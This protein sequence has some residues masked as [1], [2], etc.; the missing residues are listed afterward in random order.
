MGCLG[1]RLKRR[2][3]GGL[4]GNKFRLLKR[5]YRELRRNVH[6]R[7]LS[8][9]D[10]AYHVLAR[11]H[12]HR[13][14]PQLVDICT[15]GESG[16]QVSIWPRVGQP[17]LLFVEVLKEQVDHL[18]LEDVLRVILDV[19]ARRQGLPKSKLPQSLGLTQPQSSPFSWPPEGKS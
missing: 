5:L 4:K 6:N 18:G 12:K 15:E 13:H 10:A 3:N 19:G 7:V 1:V 14:I 17:R 8:H 2:V 11:P 9:A 16:C